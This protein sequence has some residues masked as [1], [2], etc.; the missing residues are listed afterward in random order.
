MPSFNEYVDVDID[1]SVDEFLEKCSRSEID[2]VI[3]WISEHR[4]DSEFGQ[5][6]A[7]DTA[8]MKLVGTRLYLPKDVEE[9]IIKLS[10][11]FA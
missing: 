7:F 6:D 9:Y 1:V 5:T 4:R 2:E 8:L 10:K 11:E 3:D